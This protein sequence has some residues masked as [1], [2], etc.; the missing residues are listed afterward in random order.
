MAKGAPITVLDVFRDLGFEPVPDD[1]WAVGAAMQK[2]YSEV[3]GKQPDKELRPKTGGGGSH[4][5]AVYP[6]S[7]R[8]EIERLVR[9]TASQRAKQGKL[10]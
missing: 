7:W 4:C 3:V 8:P 10:F 9:L 6:A 1:T 2:R 5:F